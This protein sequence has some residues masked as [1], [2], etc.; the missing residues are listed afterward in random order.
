MGFIAPL[1]A[2]LAQAAPAIGAAAAVAGTAVQISA[3]K[4]A[5]KNWRPPS[6]PEPPAD[7]MGDPAVTAQRMAEQRRRQAGQHGRAST[8]MSGSPLGQPAP[9]A[10]AKKYLTGA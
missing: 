5:K 6:K 10:S 4:E 2:A 3:A 9:P 7:I 1:V 8:I